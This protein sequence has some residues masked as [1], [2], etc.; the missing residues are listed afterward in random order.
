MAHQGNLG[1]ESPK[2]FSTRLELPFEDLHLLKRAL[3]HRSYVNENTD[4]LEDNE[5]LEFLGDAVLDYVVGI[6]LFH[7]FPEMTEGEMTRLRAALVKTEQLA[8]FGRAIEIGKAIRL[9][10]GEEEGGGRKRDSLL[11]ASFEAIIGALCIDVDMG[12]VQSF[13]EPLMEQAAAEILDEQREWDP[14]SL[15][16]E[17][18]QGLGYPPPFYKVLEENGPD[19]DKTFTIQVLINDVVYGTGIG[20]NK[21]DA[22]KAAAKEAL[23]N[24]NEG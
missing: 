3:T 5:R 19:H 4:A 10:K 9:G 17:R 1:I 20:K 11:C 13:M 23:E 7:R 24:Y 21:Q 15:L 18:V 14:K 22:S 2:D 6:W 16:Q 8:E 12:A